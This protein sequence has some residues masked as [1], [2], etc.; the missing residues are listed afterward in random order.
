MWLTGGELAFKPSQIECFLT[1]FQLN[2]TH[3]DN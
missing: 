3:A 2:N 1:E